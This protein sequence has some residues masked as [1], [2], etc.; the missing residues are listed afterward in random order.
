MNTVTLLAVIAGCAVPAGIAWMIAASSLR[1]MSDAEL[2]AEYNRAE[3]AFN[4]RI[5][6]VLNNYGSRYQPDSYD[7]SLITER[8]KYRDEIA[9]REARRG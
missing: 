8:N 2:H 6:F 3:A 7:R 1:F 9:R 5:A 4:V